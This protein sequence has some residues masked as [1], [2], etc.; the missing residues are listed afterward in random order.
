MGSDSRPQHPLWGKETEHALANFTVS[1]RPLPIAI[2]HA[3]AEIK[4]EAATFHLLTAAP[5]DRAKLVA[6]RDAA[7]RVASGEYDEQFLI[8]I[9]QTGSG[10][11]T[12][13]NVNE[14]VATLASQASGLAVHPND[15]V[16]RSQSSNDTFPTAVAMAAAIAVQRS[17]LP[18]AAQLVASLE[19]AAAR[20]VGI[21]TAGRTHMMDA[22]P[23][24]LSDEFDG[25]AAQIRESAE[26][27]QSVLVRLGG[28][29]LE[30]GRAHV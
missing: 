30:I 13:M 3:A 19:A 14:V 4:A 20:F 26:R 29:P 18:A 25:Y 28:V 10:T 6:V 27:I 21:V 5:D 9:F 2:V 1:G 12:N 11:S 16:N 22:V 7:T 15:D 8:D 23:I 17:L 24:L